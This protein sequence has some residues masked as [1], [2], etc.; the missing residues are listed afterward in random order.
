MNS[1]P[2]MG[3]A[4]AKWL[5]RG[6]AAGVLLAFTFL[7]FMVFHVGLVAWGRSA[8]ARDEGRPMSGPDWQRRP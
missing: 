5:D 7:G 3:R 4:V 2:M 1:A 6:L 8:L